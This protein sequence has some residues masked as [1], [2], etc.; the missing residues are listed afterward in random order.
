MSASTTLPKIAAPTPLSRA[1]RAMRYVVFRWTPVEPKGEQA[2]RA[3]AA[4]LNGTWRTL[5]D[6]RGVLLL[7]PD[8]ERRVSELP[9]GRGAVLGDMYSDDRRDVSILE[10]STQTVSAFARER[11]GSYVAIVIDRGHDVIRVLRSPDGAVPCFLT[12]RNGV[13]VVFSEAQDIIAIAPDTEPELA[14]V[15]AFL[16]YPRVVLRR[17][18]L[19]GV[20]EAAPGEAIELTRTT[21]RIVPFW[22]PTAHPQIDRF[23]QGVEA[24]RD[25]G[26]TVARALSRQEG[27]VLHRLSGGFDSSAVLGLLADAMPRE[28]LV[29]INEYWPDALEGDERVVARAVAQSQGV[30]VMELAMNPRRVHYPAILSATPT[31]KPSLSIL[32]FADEEAVDAY[33]SVG[34]D[35]LTSGQGGDH[36]FHRSRTSA[37]AADALRDGAQNLLAIALDTA[38]LTRRSVWGIF[39]DMLGQGVLRQRGRALPRSSAA[40]LLD[41]E[42]AA[43]DIDDH[44]WIFAARCETPARA[45]RI[46]H[47]RDALSYHDRSAIRTMRAFPLLLAQPVVDACLSIAPYL[48]TA[49]GTDRALARAAFA[50]FTPPLVNARSLKGETTRY[51]AATLAANRRWICDALIGG[52]LASSGLVSPSGVEKSVM[53]DW[54][55]DGV[56]ADGLYSLVAAEAW[57]RNLK[58]CKARAAA[59]LAAAA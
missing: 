2:A 51:F 57:L 4:R 32:S 1:C 27:L 20:E 53:S 31:V 40:L 50:P 7:V 41:E 59:Q 47:L 21:C 39:Q 38:R 49:G 37:I 17:T 25:A 46:G 13:H 19:A 42:F 26:K 9:H 56:A 5:V 43:P 44:P 18:G 15:A 29:C 28:Q 3:M 11:W 8:D 10:D 6:W 36:V 58:T 14:F 12:N 33:A 45:L 52:E 22:Q 16:A 34:A 30:R 23:E 54:R 48:M 24:V 55:Q 35:L